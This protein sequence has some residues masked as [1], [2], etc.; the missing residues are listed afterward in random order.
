MESQYFET[1][2]LL[3]SGFLI[4]YEH[5]EAMWWGCIEN[6]D[7]PFDF[8]AE[9]PFGNTVYWLAMKWWHGCSSAEDARE[10]DS[11]RKRCCIWNQWGQGRKCLKHFRIREAQS[12]V[13][14]HTDK[15]LSETPAPMKRWQSWVP[16][17]PMII[18]ADR[19]FE[20]SKFPVISL[21]KWIQTKALD[22]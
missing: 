8:E 6:F 9:R 22:I 4:C 13:M 14:G 19:H 3:Y 5:S 18:V 15:G 7:F 16:T 17:G 2:T 11:T 21:F 20:Q 1:T 12:E 10:Q